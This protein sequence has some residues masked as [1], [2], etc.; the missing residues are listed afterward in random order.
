MLAAKQCASGYSGVKADMWAAGVLLFVM[1]FGVDQW[2]AIKQWQWRTLI[3]R[4]ATTVPA[5]VIPVAAV[6]LAV[7]YVH[8]GMGTTIVKDRTYKASPEYLA[9]IRAGNTWSPSTFM[10]GMK[11]NRIMK[12]LL[13]L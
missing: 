9:Q 4:L 13:V 6:F 5:G 11:D 7:F 2:S 10:L 3:T 1:L 8:I 12:G